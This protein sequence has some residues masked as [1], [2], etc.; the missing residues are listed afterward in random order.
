MVAQPKVDGGDRAAV[1][2]GR[3]WERNKGEGAGVG[4]EGEGGAH[5]H[6]WGARK[7]SG[8]LLAVRNGRGGPAVVNHKRH[9]ELAVGVPLW[10]PRA[11]LSNGGEHRVVR[12]VLY[13]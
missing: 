1:S 6:Q 3:P 4:G 11:R 7:P 10:S 5:G 8:W 12:G 13:V 2:G 9:R